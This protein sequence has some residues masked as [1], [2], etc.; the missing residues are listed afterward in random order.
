MPPVNKLG[1]GG[2]TIANLNKAQFG[3][4]QVMIPTVA[5]MREFD[6][7]VSPLFSLILENQKENI[8][9]SSLRD[10]LLPRL[11]SGEIDVFGIQF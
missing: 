6:E 3:K 7:I 9:L 2:S 4:I 8:Y 1:Q 10:A 5:S 11:M